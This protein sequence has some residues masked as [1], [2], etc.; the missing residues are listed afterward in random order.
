MDTITI[1]TK[2]TGT[3]IGTERWATIR[4]DDGTWKITAYRGWGI[5]DEVSLSGNMAASMRND[6]A[7]ALIGGPR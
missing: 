2:P 5:S 7:A 4:E 3:A 1:G 6:I